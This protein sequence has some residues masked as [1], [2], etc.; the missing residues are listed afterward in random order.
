LLASGQAAWLRLPTHPTLSENVAIV[1]D[2]GATTVIGHSCERDALNGLRRHIRR[3]RTDLA[4]G[5]RLDL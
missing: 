4:T 1:A 3:L 2:S 5:D